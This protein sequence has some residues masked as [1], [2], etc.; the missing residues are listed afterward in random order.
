MA[1]RAKSMALADGLPAP[2]AAASPRRQC[3]DGS[4]PPERGKP[5]R[6]RR[7]PISCS[8]RSARTSPTPPSGWRR[9][10]PTRTAW[11][12]CR[13]TCR[14]TSP[15]G[16]SRSGAWATARRSAR[17]RPRSSRS[18]DLIVRLQAPRFF[19]QKDEVVLPRQRPQLPEDHKDR[20]R[21]RSSWR[22]ID[23]LRP[24]SSMAIPIRSC[25]RSRSR[26]AA[27]S[28]SIGA[29]RSCAKARRRSA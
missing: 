13:S 8:R 26:P 4:G 16:R 11:P 7:R 15:P 24:P 6:R 18:K 3:A 21:S 17:A 25:A 19:V 14:R 20:F 28:A 10:R 23:L 5:A 1:S 9:S 2:T 22:A 29:S 12:R 27:S